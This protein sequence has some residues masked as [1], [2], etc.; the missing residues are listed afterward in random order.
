MPNVF[1][2]REGFV[3]G[4]FSTG[5]GLGGRGR[6]IERWSPDSNMRKY[7]FACPL[8]TSCCVARFLTVHEPVLVC[9]P[10]AGEPCS[11]GFVN[12]W[13]FWKPIH[14]YCFFLFFPTLKCHM[15]I[16]YVFISSF[17]LT[18]DFF[19]SLVFEVEGQVV[20]LSCF[21]YFFLMYIP[22]AINFLFSTVFAAFY[23]F[24]YVM[25]SF[26]FVSR[27]LKNFLSFFPTHQLFRIYYCF[28]NSC[29]F[30]KIFFVLLIYF[31]SIV[32]GKYFVLLL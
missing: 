15:S 26:S 2:T 6:G 4:N 12:L 22:T 32:I 27:Y 11:K 31:Y 14:I 5:R 28:I 18:L 30:L 9:S 17:V 8:L 21:I 19:A 16:S 25:F 20:D 29:R 1:G 24:W 10:K 3:E 23:K 13:I 7:M